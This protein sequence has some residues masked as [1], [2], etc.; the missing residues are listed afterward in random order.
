MDSIY[1][2][3]F[4]FL[5]ATFCATIVAMFV[6]TKSSTKFLRIKTKVFVYT[7]VTPI[8][9][10]FVILFVFLTD[11]KTFRIFF[12]FGLI[13]GSLIR[14]FWGERKYLTD[15]NIDNTNLNIKYLT[16]LLRSKFATFNLADI[17]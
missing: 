14:A 5:L 6:A 16:P 9:F 7:F 4:T 17:S 15:I 11:F 8:L 10:G 12:G 3:L 1:A 2:Y 13:I